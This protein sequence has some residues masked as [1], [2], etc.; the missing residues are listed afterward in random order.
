MQ[1][2]IMRDVFVLACAS[3]FVLA[4]TAHAEFQKVET[5][6]DFVSAVNGKTL[7]RPLVELSVEPTG[8]ISGK[9]AVWD[10][11]GNWTWNDGFFCRSIVWGGDDLGYN[12]QEVM[13]NGRKIRFT[14]DKGTGQSADFTIR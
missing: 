7:K 13:L 2:F 9:G 12:C 6:A 8:A 11:S 3:F 14:S 5:Q 4:T 1:E 10:V